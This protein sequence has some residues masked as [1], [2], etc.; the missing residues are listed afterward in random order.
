VATVYTGRLK[1]CSIKTNLLSSL[2][3]IPFAKEFSVCNSSSR[4]L[5][6]TADGLEI[7]KM[8]VQQSLTVVASD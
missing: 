2:I 6:L 5:S 4:S 7:L 1:V 8:N 3:N